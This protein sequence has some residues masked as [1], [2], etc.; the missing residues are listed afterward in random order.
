MNYLVIGRLGDTTF[1]SGIG[2]GI[3]TIGVVSISLGLGLSGGVETL[4]SQAFGKGNNYL[5]GCYYSR[6]Q[7]ILT[8]I[9]IPQAILLYFATPILIALGLPEASSNHAGSYICI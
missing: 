1:I 4:S 8:V 7:V 9:Y 6:A 5:A 3:T 2:L